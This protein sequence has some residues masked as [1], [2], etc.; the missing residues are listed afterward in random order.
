MHSN[1]NLLVHRK[2]D[3]HYHQF[4]TGKHI[5]LAFHGFGQTGYSFKDI[6]DALG[7]EVTL[8]SFD[9]PFHGSSHWKAG[10][11]PLLK[12]HWKEILEKFLVEKEV[13]RFSVIGFSLGG[14]LALTTIEKFPTY[15]ETVILIAPDGIKTN[16]WYAMATYP[17]VLRKYFRR[18]VLKPKSFFKMLAAMNR[19]K[20]MDRGMLKF[21]AS[22]MDTIQKR[23]KVYNTW[24]IFRK[25]SFGLIPLA[26]VINEHGFPVSV[27]IG[28]YDK[29]ITDSHIKSFLNL[30]K[31]KELRLLKTGHNSILK[32][33][34][35]D[36]RFYCKK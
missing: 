14:K 27:Y 16:F 2:V 28:T 10:E 7:T 4:G 15:I 8:Y 29:I 12:E 26:A 24:I 13:D 33:V 31:N 17:Y 22:Q 18:I 35:A 32:K 1:S 9:L 36:L 30:I 23:K 5:F 3:L 20:L 21:A 6:A 19:L 11:L 25:I 34:A